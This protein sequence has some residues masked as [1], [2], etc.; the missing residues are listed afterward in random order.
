MTALAPS[1]ETAEVIKEEGGDILKLCFQCGTCTAVCPWNLVSSLNPRKVIHQ[2]QLGLVDFDS[3]DMWMCT[4]C[5]ACVERCPRDVKIID[6]WSTLRKT[7]TELGIA[8]VPDSLRLTIKNISATGNP[9]GE[10]R[11]DRANWAEGLDINE[12]S[13]CT[14]VLY[15]VGCIPSYDP[16]LQIVARNTVNVLNKAGVNF[17]F[18]GNKE[19]C[20]GECVMTSGYEDTV[21]ELAK[22]NI[23]A[24]LEAGV[25]K[26]IVSSP[27]CYTS[28]K[29]TYVKYGSSFEVVHS[30]QY[31][32]ELIREGRLKFTK[33]L[34]RKV[35]YHDP[36]YLG[37]HNGIYDEPREVLNSIPGLELV[38]MPR[39]REN[40]LC[41]G[42]GGGRIWQETRKGERFSDLRIAEAIA[43]GA[44][45]L[46]TACPFCYI[47]FKDSVLSENKEDVLEIKNIVE[48]VNEAL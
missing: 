16:Q 10:P 45:T 30:A 47:N 2:A 1:K 36:C 9:L 42:G 7:I 11:E 17:G 37:R 4:T 14:E 44:D 40:S 46:V 31:L 26:I 19:V 24:F 48:V 39:N 23:E 8:E 13:P 18:L 35:T 29:K 6:I 20:C 28:F 5:G 15:Y 43:V 22:T 3:A 41:C 12:H 32:A 34:T 27:H 25:K 33:E 38:E 21:K